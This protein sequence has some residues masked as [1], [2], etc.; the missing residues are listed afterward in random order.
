MNDKEK[1]I[2][3]ATE[4]INLKKES[5]EAKKHRGRIDKRIKRLI[6]ELHYVYSNNKEDISLLRRRIEDTDEYLEKLKKLSDKIFNWTIGTFIV[7]IVTIL[8]KLA[9]GVV[10]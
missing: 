3:V 1:L 6:Q 9:F 2:K 4:V 10:D 8:I 5:L 7:V